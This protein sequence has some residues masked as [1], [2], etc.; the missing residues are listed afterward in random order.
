MLKTVSCWL[1]GVFYAFAGVMHFVAPEFYLQIMPPYLP[2]HLGLV[3]VSGIAEFV[4]GVMVIIPSTRVLGAWGIILLLIAIFPANL[5]AAMNDV[6]LVHRPEWM[7]Q[8]TPAQAWGRLP[9]QLVL[10]AWAWWHT[11]PDV[12]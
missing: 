1:M 12:R 6:Q 2:W 9:L 7:S 4:L 8:P 3:Y 11:R 5:H 10:I